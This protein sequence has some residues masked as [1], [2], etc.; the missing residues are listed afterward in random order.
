MRS[1]SDNRLHLPWIRTVA[2]VFTLIHVGSAAASEPAPGEKNSAPPADASDTAEDDPLAATE[3]ER[4]ASIDAIHAELAEL[5]PR[6]E[7]LKGE[8]RRGLEIVV[9]QRWMELMEAV[10]ALGD[11]LL[12][13][14]EAGRDTAALRARTEREVAGITPILTRI[15]REKTQQLEENRA[16]LEKASGDQKLAIESLI[17]EDTAWIDGLFDAFVEHVLMMDRIGVDSGAL[18]E[19]AERELSARAET[20]VGRLGITRLK[21]NKI[22][23]SLERSPADSALLTQAAELEEK[24]NAISLELGQSVS[25]MR[26]LDLETSKYQQVLIEATGELTADVLDSDVALGL[27]DSWTRR[28]RDQIYD[29]G[30]QLLFKALIFLLILG[31][32]RLIASATRRVVRRTVSASRLNVSQLL[33]ETAVSISSKL[34]MT[35]GLLVG[36]SQLGLQIGPLL[37]GIGVAGFIIGFALQD[38]LGNFASGAMILIYRPYDVDDLIECAGGVYGQVSRMSLVSTT[39]L[40]VDNQTLVVPNSKIWGD[41]IKNVTAQR[42]RRIDMTFGIS[43]DSDIPHAESVLHDILMKHDKV[44]DEPESIIALHNLGDSSVD[45]V[46]RPWVETEDYWPVYWDVHRSVKMRFDEEG[47]T[48]PFPQRDVH[49][50]ASQH[51]A[52]PAPTTNPRHAQVAAPHPG[53]VP[54]EPGSDGEEG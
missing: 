44:L 17:A 42:V 20:A 2:L 25:L 36:L 39:I 32:F 47:I 46:V 18:R 35:I 16:A 50:H 22:N 11:N 21:Q 45:F 41:V 1:A 52:P 8:D 51:P 12:E 28:V 4:I 10:D 26:K 48:I 9:G 27:L 54:D 15:G 31:L 7:T 37:A 24:Y 40:T 49:V 30:P 3:A 34:V 6:L 29:N 33:Q 23:T 38:T 53:P 19:S 13:Q 14:E 5:E 43:Y